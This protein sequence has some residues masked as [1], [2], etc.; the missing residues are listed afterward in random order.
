MFCPEMLTPKKKKR[1]ASCFTIGLCNEY[2]E[3]NLHCLFV[4]PQGTRC[5]SVT[6]MKSNIAVPSFHPVSYFSAPWGDCGAMVRLYLWI[7][8]AEFMFFRS[9]VAALQQP[10]QSSISLCVPS[11]LAVALLYKVQLWIG[12]V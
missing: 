6:H 1:I 2:L 4:L 5:H 3:D 9:H 8:V 12:V 10:T 7:W 11:C